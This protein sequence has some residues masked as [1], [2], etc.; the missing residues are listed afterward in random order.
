MVYSMQTNFILII[1]SDS[2]NCPWCVMFQNEFVTDL[3][4]NLRSCDSRFRLF[5]KYPNTI[6]AYAV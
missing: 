2:N 6:Y 5:L 1:L 3:W 4:T